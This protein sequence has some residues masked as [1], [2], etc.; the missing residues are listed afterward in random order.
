M[1]RTRIKELRVTLISEPQNGPPYSPS[2]K[3]HQNAV[4]HVIYKAKITCL[5]LRNLELVTSVVYP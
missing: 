3:S 2:S 5:G 4:L 1:F